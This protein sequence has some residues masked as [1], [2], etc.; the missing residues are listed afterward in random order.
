MPQ[1]D[2]ASCDMQPLRSLLVPSLK[3]GFWSL[4]PALHEPSKGQAGDLMR[5]VIGSGG[6]GR[7]WHDPST[8]MGE[9]GWRSAERGVLW[10]FKSVC[11][12]GVVGPSPSEKSHGAEAEAGDAQCASS[13]EADK[14]RRFCSRAKPGPL[15]THAL[16]QAGTRLPETCLGI[17]LWR[18]RRQT[19]LGISG[20]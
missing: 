14:A 15:L 1:N 10:F 6:D 7:S 13:M 19:W 12:K 9:S 4:L 3:P 8:R 16:W 5:W 2:P 18:S 17:G 11:E 20:C